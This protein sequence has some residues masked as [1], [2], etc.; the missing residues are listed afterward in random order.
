MYYIMERILICASQA[1]EGDK[2]GLNHPT[3]NFS[4]RLNTK[5]FRYLHKKVL[6]T[7]N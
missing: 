2:Y 4:N 1:A 3:K 5:Y 7:H 6:V